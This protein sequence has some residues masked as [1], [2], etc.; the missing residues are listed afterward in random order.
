MSLSVVNTFFQQ[1]NS[2]DCDQDDMS[3]K[4]IS[5]PI[6]GMEGADE[7]WKTRFHLANSEVGMI[8]GSATPCEDIDSLA[9]LD[10][11]SLA[12]SSA[13]KSIG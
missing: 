8:G 3:F 5:I 10:P 13:H 6:M 2:F 7:S 9:N 1:K 12:R 11:Q 4:T